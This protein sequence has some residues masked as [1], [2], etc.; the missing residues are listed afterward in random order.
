MRPPLWVELRAVP[1]TYDL[2]PGLLSIEAIAN[3]PAHDR[4]RAAL[5]SDDIAREMVH[6]FKYADRLDLAPSG[7]R[8]HVGRELTADADALVRHLAHRLAPSPASWAGGG[9]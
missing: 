4:T 2:G 6:R 8:A 3:P 7:W 9:A 1:F 5:W